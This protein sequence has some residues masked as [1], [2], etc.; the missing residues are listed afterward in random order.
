[1]TPIP[2]FQ[3]GALFLRVGSPPVDANL[4]Q[5]RKAFIDAHHIFAVFAVTEQ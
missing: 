1:M 2:V 3:F 4:D 5:A